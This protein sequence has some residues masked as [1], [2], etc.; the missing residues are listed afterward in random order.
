ML[1]EKRFATVIMGI[2]YENYI[3]LAMGTTLKNYVFAIQPEPKIKKIREK[4]IEEQHLHYDDLIDYPRLHELHQ[5]YAPMMREYSFAR[6][7][8]DIGQTALNNI[9]NKENA[10]THILLDE[11]LPNVQ[12][13]EKIRKA[14]L[15]KAN[16]REV[17]MMDY[18]M[19]QQLYFE[20][21]GVMPEDL[22]SLQV[23]EI[24]QKELNRIKQNSK[25]QTHFLMKGKQDWNDRK[26]KTTIKE[27]VDLDKGETPRKRGR[28]R[29]G[30]ETIRK[31]KS[32]SGK[33]LE[34][35]KQLLEQRAI[36]IMSECLDSPSSVSSVRMYLEQCEEDF[37]NGE[38][39]P[40]QLRIF[41]DAI[42]FIE[43]ERKYIE[44]FARACIAFEEYD[45]C[46]RYIS[47]NLDGNDNLSY[48][49]KIKLKEVQD[50]V[51]YALRK[52]KAVNMIARG[53]TDVNRI[54]YAT[55]ALEV[56]ILD[57]M[58]RMKSETLKKESVFPEDNGGR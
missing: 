26:T 39:R 48:D 22:F 47:R 29:K 51:R 6:D 33:A 8:L 15:S 11:A 41:A 2:K 43:A 54:M 12:Q 38:L 32:K 57:I 16:I 35:E 30:E 44:S 49:D 37:E 14:L 1:T 4:V 3:Q 9:R 28:P 18:S 34:K 19:F 50:N 31:P 52:Q 20:Y 23:L 5:K 46:S 10:F 58:N 17:E 55:G 7:I 13:I 45:F 21:G 36:K 40:N 27:N 53:V 24:T 56:D 42:I 25:F